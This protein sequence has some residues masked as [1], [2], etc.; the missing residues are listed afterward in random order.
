LLEYSSPGLSPITYALVVTKDLSS[1]RH[2]EKAIKAQFEAFFS[3][4]LKNLDRV[5]KA[6]RPER[7]FQSFDIVLNSMLG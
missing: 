7:V 4:L 2:F 3:G 6:G 1:L 5:V